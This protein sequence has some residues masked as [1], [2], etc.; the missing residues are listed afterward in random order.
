[1]K[2]PTL[3][4][5]LKA[6]KEKSDW[7]ARLRDSKG[8]QRSTELGHLVNWAP[9]TQDHLN[10]LDQFFDDRKEANEASS[11][12]ERL[13]SFINTRVD[14]EGEL[15]EHCEYFS[16]FLFAAALQ[17]TYKVPSIDVS[18]EKS[19]V[20]DS[21]SACRSMLEKIAGLMAQVKTDT[22]NKHTISDQPQ[23]QRGSGW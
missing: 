5:I 16:K 1:M 13:C 8:Y 23:G 15:W 6:S 19:A 22:E 17:A 18:E 14:K 10:L 12:L 21:H 3:D 11:M 7:V 20:L 4:E 2:I 9:F